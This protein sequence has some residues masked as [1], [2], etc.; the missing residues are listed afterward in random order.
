MRKEFDSEVHKDDREFSA[1]MSAGTKYWSL[2]ELKQIQG[3]EIVLKEKLAYMD[4]KVERWLDE[5]QEG[6]GGSQ[7]DGGDTPPTSPHASSD[8]S[9]TET[10]ALTPNPCSRSLVPTSH[11]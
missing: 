2:F 4:N 5:R 8:H 7:H 11:D 6:G 9:S 3:E 10:E 1:V